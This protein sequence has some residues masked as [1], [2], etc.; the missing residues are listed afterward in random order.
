MDYITLKQGKYEAHISPGLGG[1]IIYFYDAE[2]KRELLVGSHDE[3]VIRA[4]PSSYGMPLLLP[5]NRIADG[6][7][8]Y[9]GRQYQFPINEAVRNNHIHGFFMLVEFRVIGQEHLPERAAVEL[10][11]IFDQSNPD[12]Q[13]FPHQLKIYKKYELTAAGLATTMTIINQSSD[14]IPMMFA[15]H[16]AFPLMGNVQESAKMNIRMSV[17][18]RVK[19]NERLLGTEE[20]VAGDKIAGCAAESGFSPMAEELDNV[21][22][23][24]KFGFRGAILTYPDYRARTVYE[25]DDIFRYLVVWNSQAN[26]RIICIEPQTYRNNGINLPSWQEDGLH[27]QPQQEITVRTKLSSESI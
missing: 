17:N 20:Y 15:Y 5:P 2:Q 16:T 21:Y 24:K 22:K 25:V 1:N 10:E 12:F 9:E 19:L 7:F 4:R 27:L 14:K 6:R 18:A 13:Y 23:M 3:E 26:G 8:T 11:Y